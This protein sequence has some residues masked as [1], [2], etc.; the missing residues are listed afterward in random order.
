MIDFYM[1]RNT[2]QKWVNSSE[3]MQLIHFNVSNAV[4][5]SDIIF[6]LS[7]IFNI[8]LHQRYFNYNISNAP[9]PI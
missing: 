8:Y 9:V 4:I 5:I 2:G 3:L 7:S 1:N 6:N